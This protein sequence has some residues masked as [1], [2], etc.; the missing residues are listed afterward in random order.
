MKHQPSP[1]GRGCPAAGAFTSR[2]GTG[3]GVR[4]RRKARLDYRSTR[5]RADSLLHA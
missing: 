5:A 4:P 3:E 1:L 2:N